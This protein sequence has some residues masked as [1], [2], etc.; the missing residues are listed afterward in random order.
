LAGIPEFQILPI[1]ERC[2]PVYWFTSFYAENRAGLETY[3]EN[4]GIQTRRFFC[5]LHLQ[6][7]Y[8]E[9]VDRS[10]TYPVSENAYEKGISLP[11][12]YSLTEPQQ[13]FVIDK[14]RQ[15]YRMR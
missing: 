4:E 5:P 13:E 11:S 7:C 10:K 15:F 12:A 6:P 1:D 2:T 14:I 9:M 3:L 8:Q